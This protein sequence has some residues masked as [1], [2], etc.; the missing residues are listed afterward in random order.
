MTY[1]EALH[2]VQEQYCPEDYAA[3]VAQTKRDLF[4]LNLVAPRAGLSLSDVG[5]GIGAFAPACAALGMSA[6]VVDDFRDPGNLKLGE[7]AFNAHRRFGVKVVA[8]DAS[9]GLPIE[10]G[11]DV[12]TCFASIE[13]HHNSPKRMLHS[14]LE[15]TRPGGLFV[16]SV[17]NAADLMKRIEML[18]GRAQWSPMEEWYE[19][20]EFRGHVREPL[21]AD[22]HYIASDLGLRDYRIVGRTFIWRESGF[23]KLAMEAV[24]HLIQLRPSLNSELFLIARTPTAKP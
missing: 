21:I 17:P 14:M 5:S 12:M 22:L 11:F 2:A 24:A 19:A 18:L 20:S 15:H 6:T 7:A 13:H 8:A 1:A 4:R 16:L 9:G 10:S 3:T 23:A